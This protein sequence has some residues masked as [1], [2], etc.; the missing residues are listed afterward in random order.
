MDA[1]KHLGD[2]GQVNACPQLCDVRGSYV[3]QHKHTIRMRPTCVQVVSRGDDFYRL[4]WRQGGKEGRRGLTG[5]SH[6][7]LRLRVV[8]VGGHVVL[9]SRVGFDVR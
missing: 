1:L 9:K 5:T 7:S 3:T 4:C 6:C 8:Y 2:A